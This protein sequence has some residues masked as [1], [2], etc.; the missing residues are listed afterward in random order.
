M[1]I[2]PAR[3]IK[4]INRSSEGDLSGFAAGAFLNPATVLVVHPSEISCTFPGRGP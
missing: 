4:R 3:R 2:L 1:I